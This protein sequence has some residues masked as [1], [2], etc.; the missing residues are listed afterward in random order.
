M[1]AVWRNCHYSLGSP[2]TL[3][4]PNGVEIKSHN[5]VQQGG[6][7]SSGLYAFAKR[8]G[9]KAAQ[10]T[11]PDTLNVFAVLDDG[12]ICGPAQ[13]V[14]D[15]GIRL[16]RDHKDDGQQ[17]NWSKCKFLAHPDN[18]LPQSVIDFL[19]TR[20]VPIVRDATTLLGA[21]VGWDRQKMTATAMD[22]HRESSLL[23]EQL[24]HPALPP[25]EAMLIMRNCTVPVPG[26]LSRILPP[27]V[28]RQAAQAF[29][30]D[31]LDVAVTKLQLPDLKSS[32]QQ[33]LRRKLIDAG[34]GLT[35][36]AELSPIAHT[37]ALA[38]SATLLCEP[39]HRILA[40]GL[41]RADSV[42][43]TDWSD[44]LAA[45]RL[46]A[47]GDDQS[48]ALLPP[49]DLPGPEALAWY[50]TTGAA[51]ASNNSKLQRNLT[52]IADGLRFRR[53]LDTANEVDKARLHSASGKSASAWLT[54]IP[55]DST[56]RLL[57]ENTASHPVF[58]S[59]FRPTT[60]LHPPAS[61]TMPTHNLTSITASHVSKS[62][63][64]SSICVMIWSKTLFICGLDVLGAVP[65]K[66][67]RT[68]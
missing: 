4:L 44:A 24:K 18:V 20:N 6:C 33:Q 36:I 5:G 59:A 9:Y 67:H 27:A 1:Q 25:Q 17:F 42:F 50:A 66:S 12:T 37:C 38:S 62:A 57:Q 22:I 41:P 45:T 14:I 56:C 10:D 60:T 30:H 47:T 28:L 52:H 51:L 53:A 3:R 58:G 31:L 63:A 21:P 68:W 7:L 11:H 23:F 13:D 43:A 29:D 64:L 2:T 65:S 19:V 49:A 16:E 32:Q 26:Y 40:N 34:F 54:A 8:D 35:S 39:R 15:S 46:A 55:S 61:A 48:A